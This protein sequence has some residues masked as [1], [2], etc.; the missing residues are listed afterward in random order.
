MKSQKPRQKKV[1]TNK[2]VFKYKG[3]F[4]D[5]NFSKFDNALVLIDKIRN[6]EISLNDAIDEQA[7]FKSDLGEIKRIK[8]HFLKESREARTNVENLYNSRKAAIDFL[9]EYTSRLSKARY[10]DKK[11]KNRT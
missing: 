1:D 4:R 7:K 3:K 10:Q 11:C 8:K 9:N 2:L 5:K 6:G